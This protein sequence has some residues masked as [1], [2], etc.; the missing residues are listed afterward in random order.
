MIMI[1]KQQS[2]LI[3]VSDLV[4]MAKGARDCE[5]GGG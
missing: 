5:M 3:V 4:K 1:G 2:V